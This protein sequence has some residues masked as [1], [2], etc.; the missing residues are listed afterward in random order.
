MEF[1]DLK[2]QQERRSQI[3]A[4]IKRVLDQD[5][6]YFRLAVFLLVVSC[7]A[8][9]V[10]FM[11]GSAYSAESAK[12]NRKGDTGIARS[13]GSLLT[14]IGDYGGKGVR[15]SNGRIDVPKLITVLKKIHAKDYMHLVWTRRAYPQS[16]E[17]F[18][19][20]APQFQEANLN[21]W[22]YITPPD[23]GAPDPFGGDYVTWAIECA[24]IAKKYPAVKGIVIDDFNSNVATFTPSYCK[25][26]MIEARKIAPDLEL[27]VVGYF[28]KQSKIKEHIEQ[29][30]FDG[31][32]FPYIAT[33]T[34]LHDVS[35][36][37]SQINSYRQYLDRATM[38]MKNQR[39]MPLVVMVYASKLSTSPDSPTPAYVKACVDVALG[40]TR[41]G[42]ANGVVTYNLPKDQAEYIDS[43]IT[44]YKA[45]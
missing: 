43:V 40:A 42:M 39:R 9:A 14:V 41:D 11:A 8:F 6:C 37:S 7:I 18:Q 15:K 28:G 26:M 38:M 45:W 10:V 21:L 22:L 33:P 44:S 31:I 24:K 32:I 20:M 29:L 2:A 16:W 12:Y 35:Q 5:K 34:N 23:E 36:L 3:D 27:F 30:A 25:K 19:E 17:D 13:G 4:T 1:I